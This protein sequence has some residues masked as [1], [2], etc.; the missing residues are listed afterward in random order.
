MGAL[1]V[2]GNGSTIGSGQWAMGA[3]EVLGNGSTRGSGQ[4]GH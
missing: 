2:L 4:W 1:E 3:L